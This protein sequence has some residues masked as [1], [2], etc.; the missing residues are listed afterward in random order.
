MAETLFEDH[1]DKQFIFNMS[2]GYDLK[3]IQNPRMDEFIGRLIDSSGEE[4]LF[5]LQRGTE[6]TG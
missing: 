4:A 5:R 6:E 3:G 2:V 1:R